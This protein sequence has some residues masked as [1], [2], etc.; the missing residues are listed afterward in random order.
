MAEIPDREGLAFPTRC[1]SLSSVLCLL[2]G[3]ARAWSAGDPIP[4]GRNGANGANAPGTLN[5][6]SPTANLVSINIKGKWVVFHFPNGRFAGYH[7]IG[8]QWKSKHI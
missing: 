2:N 6:S 4:P 7:A 5:G 1:T 8:L 3:H